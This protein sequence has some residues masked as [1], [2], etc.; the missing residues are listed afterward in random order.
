M[1]M[2]Y[3]PYYP[4]P[5]FGYG[6]VMPASPYG[7]PPNPYMEAPGYVVPYTQLHLSDYRRMLNPHYTPTMAYHT[8]RFRYQHVTTPRETISSEVQTDPQPQGTSDSWLSGASEPCARSVQSTGSDSGQGST[9]ANTSTSLNLEA[10]LQAAGRDAPSDTDVGVTPTLPRATATPKGACVF[11]REEVRIEC[12]GGLSGLKIVRSHETTAESTQDAP[13][14]LAQCDIWSVSSA[15]GIIPLYRS[16]LPEGA[17]ITQDAVCLSE[18]LEQQPSVPSYPDILLVGG[19]PSSS[20]EKPELPCT[21]GCE[22]PAGK[23]AAEPGTDVVQVCREVRNGN[24]SSLKEACFKILRLPFE[25]RYLEELRKVEESVWS[26]KPLVPFIPSAEW[27]SQHRLEDAG[28]ETTVPTKNEASDVPM[29]TSASQPLVTS[30]VAGCEESI[31]V[32]PYLPS[33]SWLA[34]FGNVYYYS[35]LPPSVHEHCNSFSTSTE[36]LPPGGKLSQDSE[37]QAVV[38]VARRMA[39][40]HTCLLGLDGKGHICPKGQSLSPNR[41]ALVPR[42]EGERTCPRCIKRSVPCGPT[43][44]L[45]GVKRHR[46][47]PPSPPDMPPQHHVACR[48]CLGKALRKGS[49]Q[50]VLSSQNGSEEMEYEAEGNSAHS[51]ISRQQSCEGKRAVGSGGAMASKRHS[52]K[53]SVQCAKLREKN[54]TCKDHGDAGVHGGPSWGHT[55]MVGICNEENVAVSIPVPDKRRTRE[56][57]CNTQ[58]QAEKSWEGTVTASCKGDFENGSRPKNLKQR[59]QRALSQEKLHSKLSSKVTAQPLQK[60]DNEAPIEG[61][62]SQSSWTKHGTNRRDTRY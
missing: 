13:G 54:C 51:A 32:P 18:R 56:Q 26:V 5:G 48:C 55:G 34:D 33:G 21:K 58:C 16:P 9:S 47:A 24:A 6:V 45:S 43:L 10:S 7:F 31:T 35:K 22:A 53:C 25:M 49:G 42:G 20:T 52:D 23:P 15:E 3:G 29:E 61:F 57:R 27:M 36:Q 59:K 62:F 28:T 1:P 19:S 39:G 44:K 37:G 46:T 14:D 12:S 17:A 41:N 2:Q 40:K 60:N 11:Q 4:F 50:N 38:A 30:P 8:R